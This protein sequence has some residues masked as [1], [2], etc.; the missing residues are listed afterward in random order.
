MK[1][2]FSWSYSRW[3][4]FHSCKAKYKYQFIDKIPQPPSPAMERGKEI[5][6]KGEMFIKG[7]IR[8]MPPA[9]KHFAQEL[10]S[11]KK[12][13]AEAEESWAVTSEWK[14]CEWFS[15]IAWCRSKTDAHLYVP[16]EKEVVVIDFKTGRQYPSHKDQAE[17]YSLKGLLFYPEANV[18]TVEF[19]YLDSG[20]LRTY[21][22]NRKAVKPLTTRWNR[23]ADEMTREKK[24]APNPGSAC[25]WCPYSIHKGGPCIKAKKG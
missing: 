15:N 8:G 19:W 6:S 21:E 13:G 24:F 7:K 10:R 14:R 22:Y 17:L 1:K 4:C 23:R 20:D 25:R 16:E 11:I 18:A 9:Y 3:S 5:H 2:P 12:Y